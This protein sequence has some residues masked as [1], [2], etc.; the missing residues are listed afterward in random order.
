MGLVA[1]V[2]GR[3]SVEGSSRVQVVR[4]S[5][6]LTYVDWGG[7]KIRGKVFILVVGR[8][9]MGFGDLD[10]GWTRFMVWV[11]VIKRVHLVCNFRKIPQ[12]PK[13]NFVKDEGL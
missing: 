9:L 10:K 5:G 4:V 2:R 6:G 8:F 1:E 3:L 12:G 11:V 13:C 7:N